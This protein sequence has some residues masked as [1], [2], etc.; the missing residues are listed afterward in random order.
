MSWFS[1]LMPSKIRTD[2]LTKSTVPEGL[3][4]KCP[5][6]NAI[7]YKAEVERNLE[8]CPKCDHHMRIN[9]RQRLHLFLDKEQR[10]ELGEELAPTD[11]LK[12]KDSKKYKDR[13]VQA[14]KASG[15]KDA[16]SSCAAG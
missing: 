6:C 10:Q 12:F 2:A 14:Q 13:L 16:S 1:K 4:T 9:A 3:W 5:Q 7:L 8:V 11:P 15:E